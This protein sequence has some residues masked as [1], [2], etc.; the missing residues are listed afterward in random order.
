MYELIAKLVELMAAI[1]DLR[2]AKAVAEVKLKGAEDR[3]DLLLEAKNLW[4]E[5]AMKAESK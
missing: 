1:G 5:R 4:M 3:C 2:E